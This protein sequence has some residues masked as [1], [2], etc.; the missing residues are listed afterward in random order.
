MTGR[1]SFVIAGA[2]VL[3]LVA[4]AAPGARADDDPPEALF[5]KGAAALEAGAYQEGIDDFEALGDRGFVHPDASFDRGLAYVM[6]VR[7]KKDR[8]GDLG[9]AAAAFEEAT[10]LRPDD[11]PAARELQR[12]RA[13]LTRRRSRR[14]RDDIE[15]KPTLDR[16]LVGLL[17]ETAWEV[18]A[19]IASAALALGLYLRARKGGAHVAGSIVTPV[20]VGA[21]ALLLPAAIEARWLAANTRAGVVVASDVNLVDVTGKALAAPPLPEGASV[22]A[23]ARDGALVHVRWGAA[24]GWAPLSSVRLMPR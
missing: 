13:E 21:L 5:A 2:C 12:V 3:G 1:R 14:G 8:P 18:L 24:E 23:G 20:A 16:V 19:L 9:R 15:A 6:R 22:E 17:A 11:E 10:L 7:A 4:L